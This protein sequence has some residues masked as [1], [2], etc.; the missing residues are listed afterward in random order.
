MARTWV[1]KSCGWRSVNR[2]AR[3]P[4]AGLGS[5]ER[6]PMGSLS[7]PRSSVRM[8]TGRSPI[9]LRMLAYALKCS[10]SLGSSSRFR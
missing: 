4:S 7:P 3:R 6:C 5:W 1:R 9:W 8:T 2:I 10:S